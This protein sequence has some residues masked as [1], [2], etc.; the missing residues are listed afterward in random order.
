MI[1]VERQSAGGK[2]VAG[3]VKAS[4]QRFFVPAMIAVFL[5]ALI[6]RMY[7]NFYTSHDNCAF[8]GDANEYV[9]EAIVLSQPVLRSPEFIK[10]AISIIQG[11]ASAA[12]LAHVHATTAGFTELHR[13][14]PLY[15]LTIWGYYALFGR[16]VS[17]ID[18]VSPILCTSILS[19]FIC[20]LVAL[21]T[22][23]LWNEKVGLLAGLLACIYP[24][25][26]FS[27]GTLYSE[28]YTAFAISVICWGISQ[29][30]HD[31]KPG[32]FV[33]F[34]MGLCMAALWLTRPPAMVIIALIL[35]FLVYARFR[36]QAIVPVVT[37]FLGFALIILPYCA[38]QKVAF[39]HVSGIVERS[40]TYNMVMGN[41]YGTLGWLAYPYPNVKPAWDG[42]VKYVLKYGIQHLN[43]SL[44]L[45]IDK[46][47]RLIKFPFN[48]FR[49]PIGPVKYAG[50]VYVH[51]I[52]LLFAVIGLSL[53]LFCEIRKRADL[54]RVV[55]RLCVLFVGLHGFAYLAFIAMGR[56]FLPSCPVLVIFS[57]VGMFELATRLK[58]AQNR[59]MIV[60][61]LFC[62]GVLMLTLQ[63]NLIPVLLQNGI[64]E[65]VSVAFILSVA[66]KAIPVVCLGVLLILLQM[67]S[68]DFAFKQSPLSARLQMG[69]TVMLLL[70]CLPLAS[71]PARASG[72]RFESSIVL[73]KPGQKVTQQIDCDRKYL[74]DDGRL[75]LLVDVANY[76]SLDGLQFSVNGKKTGAKRIPGFSVVPDYASSFSDSG[77]VISWEGENIF[78]CLSVAA[79]SSNADVRQWYIVPLDAEI[80]KSVASKGSALVEIEKTNFTPSTTFSEFA[81]RK[82]SYT[83]PSVDLY[84]W[85]KTFYA[86]ENVQDWADPRYDER[87][88][89]LHTMLLND[90]KPAGA[91]QVASIR[92]VS[93]P[94]SSSSADEKSPEKE[95]AASEIKLPLITAGVSQSSVVKLTPALPVCPKSG[96]LVLKVSGRVKALDGH[97]R[98]HIQLSVQ[99]NQ[100]E[101]TNAVYISPWSPKTLFA[102]SEWTDFS[103]C[104]PLYASQLPGKI[105]KVWLTTTQKDPR[106]PFVEA[107]R[108]EK[109]SRFQLKDTSVDIS[110]LPERPLA[111]GFVAF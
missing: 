62:L 104:L 26:I 13:A 22:K 56:Y 106:E 81:F 70:L 34:L 49:T 68:R 54:K 103:F 41:N 33:S 4:L 14:G 73:D 55:A 15:P 51:Q 10:E 3:E 21:T 105:S 59:A 78:D 69:L 111:Q 92:L 53:G 75:Y 42:G 16:A 8:V 87:V 100:G 29:S 93:V 60:T 47:L 2:L 88:K 40:A 19:S 95:G 30:M 50:Q 82:N 17:F 24:G 37:F 79:G 107:D 20:V 9:R 98:P 97:P 44:P 84:S 74:P 109:P 39:N 96:L 25:F 48:D 110:V 5:I 18:W 102:Q 1:T 45:Q 52:I 28:T 58:Q 71:F 94:N 66:L 43:E 89:R 38:F 91:S 11:N 72:R 23:N 65:N 6:V 63:I 61:T 76:A 31:G 7:F 108:I 83:L 27:S 57:A 99:C 101:K 64:T 36:R 12:T 46:V 85:E 86:V 67:S 77:G 90:R 35:P 80:A 32:N